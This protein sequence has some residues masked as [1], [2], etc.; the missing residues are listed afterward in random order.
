MVTPEMALGGYPPLDLVLEGDWE[1]AEGLWLERVQV[2][3]LKGDCGILL[4]HIGVRGKK[5]ANLVSA[6]RGGNI[7]WSQAKCLLPTSDVFDEARYFEPGDEIQTISCE[8]KRLGVAVCEDMWSRVE[9]MRVRRQPEVDPVQQLIDLQVEGIVVLAASPFDQ[10]KRRLREKVHADVLKSCPVP[11][12]YVNQVSASDSLLFDG[13]SFLM[14]KTGVIVRQ[15]AAFKPEVWTLDMNSTERRNN[16]REEH[17]QEILIRGIIFGI[18]EY[19]RKSGQSKVWVGLSGGIDSAVVLSLAVLALGPARVHAVFMP[20]EYTALMSHE[21]AE[22]LAKILQVPFQ[23]QPIRLVH[24]ILRRQLA[25]LEPQGALT[26][27]AAE[28]VQA[29]IR[30]MMLMALANQHGGLVLGTSNKS[31]LA[32]GYSTLY[33][34]LVG[35]L[36]PIGDLYKTEVFEVAKTLN[37]DWKLGIPQ[38]ILDRPPSAELREN[39]TDQDTLPPYPLLDGFLRAVIEE[40]EGIDTLIRT[41][42]QQFAMPEGWVKDWYARVQAAEYK[43]YQ[44]A[45]VLKV[46]KKAFGIGR[47][48]PLVGPN[49]WKALFPE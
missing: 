40:G 34:D 22:A 45:P 47:R 11:L 13:S 28:N 32:T 31:E 26:G 37:Q 24:S 8:G 12:L 19:V 18:Q 21:D 46:S 42:E 36:L 29:R 2:L 7:E 38:R 30:G 14:D 39:Q 5:R 43:R 10:Q 48:V 41:F 20:S 16:P 15:A 27:L 4:G 3:T 9:G 6:L 33:G 35:A 23:V 1:K 44:A 49:L 17:P 25:A